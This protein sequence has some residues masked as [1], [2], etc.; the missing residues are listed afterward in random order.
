ML[1]NPNDIQFLIVEDDELAR[2]S[3]A[4]LL[5]GF[6]KVS[7]AES[8]ENALDLIKKQNFSMA[9]VDLD[10]EGEFAGMELIRPLGE[11]GCYVC[12]LSGREEDGVIEEAYMRGCEDYLSKPF[13]KSDLINVIKKFMFLKDQNLLRDFFSKKYITQDPELVSELNVI[14]ELILTERPVLITGET[15]TGKTLVANLI[16]EIICGDEGSFVQ[17]NCSEVP[18]NLL[19]SELFGHVKGAF[20]GANSGKKGK[21]ELASGGT[22]F[23]DEIATMPMVLQQKLLKAIEEKSFYPLGSEVEVKV[24]FR[25]ISATCEDLNGMMGEGKFRQDLYFRIEGHNIHLKPLR[26]RAEDIQPLIKHFLGRGTRRVVVT[27]EAKELLRSY[28]W[29]GNIRELQKTVDILKSNK[30]GIINKEELPISVQKN[31]KVTSLN[32]AAPITQDVEKNGINNT[33]LTNESHREF[34]KKHGLKCLLSKIEEETIMH[35]YQENNEKVRK[36]LG[37]LK[38]SNSA[39]Y[40]V[41]DRLKVEDSLEQ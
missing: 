39:F 18:E 5:R 10:L 24:N 27:N 26:E 38:I 15:G 11:I 14:N 6:G 20:T 12:V 4:S 3:L 13:N 16:H 8:A 21:L 36:T 25:L 23:L 29:P 28:N 9:F 37:D 41:M 2:M 1:M 22:L 7:C 32:T 35:F 30:K 40:R 33:L 19:E 34:I 17:L 31:L